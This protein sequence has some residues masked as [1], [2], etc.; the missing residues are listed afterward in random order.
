[1]KGLLIKDFIQELL[2]TL[3]IS[4]KQ[5][6]LPAMLSLSLIHIYSADRIYTWHIGLGVWKD[7]LLVRLLLAVLLVRR[8][9]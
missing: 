4:D 1:M 9:V 6:M 5:E 7:G 3:N 8:C 2:E